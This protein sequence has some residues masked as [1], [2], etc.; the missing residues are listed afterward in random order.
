[1]TY[2]LLRG[3]TRCRHI[4]PTGGLA[5]PVEARGAGPGESGEGYNLLEKRVRVR[6]MLEEAA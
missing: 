3:T 5:H 4:I 1:M 2:A 6:G